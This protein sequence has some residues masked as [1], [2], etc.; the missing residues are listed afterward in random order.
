MEASLTSKTS[1]GPSSSHA[2]EERRQEEVVQRVGSAAS[3][4]AGERVL[5]RLLNVLVD[6]RGRLSSSPFSCSA[7]AAGASGA[8][9]G[10]A[11]KGQGELGMCIELIP[12]RLLA[13]CLLDCSNEL[14]TLHPDKDKCKE[15]EKEREVPVA[16]IE[17]LLLC[18]DRETALAEAISGGHWALAML[19]GSVC[20]ANSYKAMVS[21]Y[22]HSHFNISSGLYLLSHVYSDQC[23]VGISTALGHSEGVIASSTSDKADVAFI[24]GRDYDKSFDNRSLAALLRLIAG[25]VGNPTSSS[26][27]ALFAIGAD[28]EVVG[29]V[30]VAHVCY[31]LAGALPSPL[32]LPIVEGEKKKG[33]YSLL[34]LSNILKEGKDKEKVPK[35]SIVHNFCD[36]DVLR[37]LRMTEILEW[38]M[39]CAPI[40]STMTSKGDKEAT[41]AYINERACALKLQSTM[42]PHKLRLSI[43]LSD[44]GMTRS[45]KGYLTEIRSVVN[46]LISFTDILQKSGDSSITVSEKALAGA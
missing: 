1:L 27:E 5:W 13:Q 8:E 32:L 26:T 29:N 3:I 45:A 23:E 30:Y 20:D 35:K 37:A 11:A 6:T 15:K 25:L 21:R 18:G 44:I 2:S 41:T 16:R 33:F 9:K 7:S 40:G 14:Y 17:A 24:K 19:V 31:L 42:G 38:A 46:N 34:G 28:L 12:E 4:L 43:C 36:I 10:K 22:A 39:C